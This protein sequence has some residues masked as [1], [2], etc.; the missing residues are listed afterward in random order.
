MTFRYQR[1]PG[2]DPTKPFIGR[3]VMPVVLVRGVL[4][5][6]AP[7]YALLDSGADTTIFPA[8][9]AEMVGI[10]DPEGGEREQTMGIAGQTAIVYYHECGIQLVGDNRLIQMSIGFSE[11]ITLPLLGRAFFAH[12]KSVAFHQAKEAVE[13]KP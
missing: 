7:I 1:F 2:S 13:F 11:Q 9:I 8:E 4:R 6:P 5:T 12:Y 3:P 10:L